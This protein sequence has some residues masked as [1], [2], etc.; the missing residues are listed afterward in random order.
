MWL[1]HNAA[2]SGGGQPEWQG[3]LSPHASLSSGAL[4][5]V[6]F[7]LF[8]FFLLVSHH[9]LGKR[10]QWER[11]RAQNQAK[12]I[13]NF[14]MPP[15][16]RFWLLQFYSPIHCHSSQH[17]SD[18]VSSWE[19]APCI[20]STDDKTLR[21]QRVLNKKANLTA[22]DKQACMHKLKTWNTCFK[23]N[24]IPPPKKKSRWGNVKWSKL[25]SGWV[26][27]LSK[28][29]ML[30]QDWQSCVLV[31][32]LLQELGYCLRLSDESEP[33]RLKGLR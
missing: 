13:I 23:K 1:K 20:W 29:S 22:Q 9:M 24:Q 28:Q 31:Q 16:L 15:T 6:D 14:V 10:P 27:S 21:L 3:E 2:G 18:R 8:F 26:R 4:N 33:L 11:L 7:F 5:W 12:L 25:R 30:R 19:F 17:R 32:R